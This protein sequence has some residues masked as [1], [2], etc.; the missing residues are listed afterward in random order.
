MKSL[1]MVNRRAGENVIRSNGS[2]TGVGRSQCAGCVLPEDKA[3]LKS[4]QQGKVEC[5]KGE[6]GEKV[7]R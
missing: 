2:Q 5:E 4:H 7:K 6:K 3:W 1:N